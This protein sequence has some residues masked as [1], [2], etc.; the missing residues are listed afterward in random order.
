MSDEPLAPD[1]TTS[2]QST[3]NHQPPSH[4]THQ[5]ICENQQKKIDLNYLQDLCPSDIKAAIVRLEETLKGVDV[6]ALSTGTD[7]QPS[8]K[9]NLLNLIQNL[10]S[11]LKKVKLTDGKNDNPPVSVINPGRRGR[12]RNN[13]H[14]IGVSSEEL[15]SARKWLEQERGESIKFS[16]ENR[17]TQ[18][19]PLSQDIP[20]ISTAAAVPIASVSSESSV[21][22]SPQISPENYK[23][24]NSIPSVVRSCD[25]H[26][27]DAINQQ[28]SLQHRTKDSDFNFEQTDHE[29]CTVDRQPVQQID[30]LTNITIN[31]QPINPLNKSNKFFAKKSKIKRANTIDIP[32][33]LKMQEEKKRNSLNGYSDV[34]NKL[35]GL[36]KPID[37]SD[38]V[39]WNYYSSHQTIS[40][41]P[42]PNFEPKTENDRKFLALINKN[43]SNNGNSG[44]SEVNWNV[45]PTN[46]QPYKTFSYRQTSS[47][48]DKNWKSRFSNIKTAFDQQSLPTSPSSLPPTSSRRSSRDHDVD[49][50]QKNGEKTPDKSPDRTTKFS[51]FENFQ[52]S[53]HTYLPSYHHPGNIGSKLPIFTHAATSPFKKIS[54]PSPKYPDGHQKINKI[55]EKPVEKPILSSFLPNCAT[56]GLLKAKVK[57]FDHQNQP[58]QIP[59]ATITNYNRKSY[60]E[61]TENRLIPL[62]QQE[63]QKIYRKKDKNYGHYRSNGHFCDDENDADGDD[64]EEELKIVGKYPKKNSIQQQQHVQSVAV[65]TNTTVF[66]SKININDVTYPKKLSYSY[67]AKPEEKTY[68]MENENPIYV[69][70]KNLNNHEN[71]VNAELNVDRLEDK[72]FEKIY[73][74]V[75]V[76]KMI[77]NQDISPNKIVTRYTSAIGTLTTNGLESANSNGYQTINKIQDSSFRA[78]P[79]LNEAPNGLQSGYQR[80]PN[81]QEVVGESFRVTHPVAN[82]REDSNYK[83]RPVYPVVNVPEEVQQSYRPNYPVTNIKEQTYTSFR[84]PQP[85]G[86]VQED[87]QRHNLLQQN[88]IRRLQ[89]K[90]DEESSSPLSP[91]TIEANNTQDKINIFEEKS[92]IIPIQLPKINVINAIS[93]TRVI[94]Q[95]SFPIKQATIPQNSIKTKAT[96]IDSSDEYLVSCANR[97]N[98]S[99]VLSKSESWHQLAMLNKPQAVQYLQVPAQNNNKPPKSNSALSNRLS[100]NYDNN[101]GILKKMEEKVMRYFN[102][103]RT[104][105]TTSLDCHDN[106]ITTTATTTIVNK[107]DKK[108]KRTFS[109]SKN[110][111]TLVRSQTMPHIFDD[112][113]DVDEAFDSLFEEATRDNNRH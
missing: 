58:S 69:P 8:E 20:S 92:Q 65:Q 26:I 15:A 2:H 79:V 43:N 95:P 35:S 93:P 13:R 37:I 94:I 53:S 34:G 29:R 51:K 54:N 45:N 81:Q 31:Q 52:D 113:L 48:A 38:K 21:P 111:N 87:I 106:D 9:S 24:V 3:T 11:N 16:S 96:P 61:R 14:T 30:T 73:M 40:P 64:E 76:D 80:P 83:Y 89:E 63:Q 1:P 4:E 22:Q 82:G 46:N 98:R 12:H 99:I 112:N 55:M 49:I 67:G 102:N 56:N 28:Q 86:H 17:S 104:N 88:L 108:N 50:V 5:I 101:N 75:E 25:K 59:K 71:Y 107:R 72:T 91:P 41:A 44:S 7:L 105:S 68:Y 19:Q 33:Y 23:F 85:S 42:V 6:D 27:K 78:G 77:E 84:Q 109:S 36:R 18:Q 74:P 97:P 90:S 39:S 100:K 57:I 66:P 62:K 10:V 103:S 60:P 32:N 110:S 70:P 47:T